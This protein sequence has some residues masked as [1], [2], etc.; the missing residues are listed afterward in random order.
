MKLVHEMIFEE[1]ICSAFEDLD[2]FRTDCKENHDDSCCELDSCFVNFFCDEL[3]IIQ[4][5]NEEVCVMKRLIFLI[6]GINTQKL[7]MIFLQ[8]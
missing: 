2:A 1:K 3:F 7:L 4:I 5:K 8:P 6:F